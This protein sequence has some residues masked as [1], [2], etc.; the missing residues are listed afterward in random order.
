[1]E[2]QEFKHYYL[3]DGLKIHWRFRLLP[4]GFEAITL[5]GHIFDVQKKPNL[6]MFLHTKQG[7]IMVN[8]ERIHML[9]AET[10]KTKYF[11]FYIYYIWYWFI[12]LFKWG[13]KDNASYYHIPFERE[14]FCKENNF[15]YSKSHWREYINE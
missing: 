14:A 5:F 6:L 2:I 8:H 4:K 1:M 7:K 15:N 12:G 3:V 11:G 9:Q 10:F 13:C